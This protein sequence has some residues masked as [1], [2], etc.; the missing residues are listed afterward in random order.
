MQYSHCLNCETAI[1]PGQQF[2]PNC[3]Q[4]IKTPRITYGGLLYD[5]FHHFVKVEKSFFQLAKGLLLRPGITAIEFVEGKRKKYFPPISFMGICVALMLLINGWLK[6]YTIHYEPAPSVLARITDKH[7]MQLYLASLDRTSEAV[8][9]ANHYLNILS[10]AITPWFAF[11]LWIFFKRRGWTMAE[12]AVAYLL[13]SA[14]SNLVSTMIFSPIFSVMSEGTFFYQV[15]FCSSVLL[16]TIY[17][18]WGM[19]VFFRFNTNAGF[20]K[21]LGALML[22]G[23]IGFLLV[24]LALFFYVYRGEYR[25][26]LQYL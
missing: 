26:V 21:V 4:K 3:G 22:A 23:T 19:K 20:W 7:M 15:V 9:W 12:I 1:F 16:Q 10:V 11:F 2:C 13:F 5:F 17:I 8:Q 6:P 14:F 24:L 25:E 18:T